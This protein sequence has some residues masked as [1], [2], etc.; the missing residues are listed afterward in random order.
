MFFKK[1]NNYR[2]RTGH[3]SGV[4]HTFKDISEAKKKFE[5]SLRNGEKIMLFEKSD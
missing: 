4:V 5:S 1:L 3:N 2:W